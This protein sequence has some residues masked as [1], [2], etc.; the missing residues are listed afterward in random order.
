MPRELKLL[1]D[2]QSVQGVIKILDFFERKDS[3]VYILDRLPSSKDLFDFITERGCL[4]EDLAKNFLRQVVNT[5]QACQDKG[6]V[7]RDIKDENLIVNLHSLQLKLIDFGSGAHL[8]EEAYTDFDGTRVY[9]PPEWIQTSKYFA[10]H[11]TVWSLGILLYDMVVGDIPF[12]ND[13]EIC[14]AKL[15]FPKDISSE[16]QELIRG[17]L[18]VLPQNRILLSDILSHR[19]FFQKTEKTITTGKSMNSKIS[20]F[21]GSL[22]SNGSC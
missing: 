15:D 17:C 12:E 8:K 4:E 20:K 6:V 3:F 16:C 19:W 22:S 9:A 1:L 2:V 13:K 11:A 7:H 18:E 21:T 14:E 5:V 10:D